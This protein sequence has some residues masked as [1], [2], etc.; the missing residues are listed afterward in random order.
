MSSP[1]EGAFYRDG[2]EEDAAMLGMLV[3]EH[4]GRRLRGGE[5]RKE[6]SGQASWDSRHR[7]RR[8]GDS[9]DM[10]GTVSKERWSSPL[11]Q[12]NDVVPFGC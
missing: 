3:G 7:R 1:V 6:G 10:T 5:A 8:G 4:F 12:P 11:S 2:Y 9:L